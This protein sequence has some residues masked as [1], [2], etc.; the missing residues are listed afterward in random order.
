MLFIS[1]KGSPL[2]L[3]GSSNSPPL[4]KR[5]QLGAKLFTPI[6]W[7]SSIELLIFWLTPLVR[8]TV[9]DEENRVDHGHINRPCTATR[10]RAWERIRKVM[11]DT[12]CVMTPGHFVTVWRDKEKATLKSLRIFIS[13]FRCITFSFNQQKTHKNLGQYYLVT[14][15]ICSYRCKHWL[16]RLPFEVSRIFFLKKLKVSK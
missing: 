7:R 13:I 5:V 8:R 4:L 11:M 2:L 6:S 9:D 15:P 1:A 14:K 10:L 3:K 12:N 16:F